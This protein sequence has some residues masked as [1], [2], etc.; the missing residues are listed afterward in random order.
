MTAI[1]Q[2]EANRLNDPTAMNIMVAE[3]SLDNSS[4]EEEDITI[5]DVQIST[6]CDW[7]IFGLRIEWRQ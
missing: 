1:E 5:E 3:G 2:A 7:L 6:M 4:I